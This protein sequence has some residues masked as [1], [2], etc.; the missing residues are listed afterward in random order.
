MIAKMASKRKAVTKRKQTKGRVIPQEQEEVIKEFWLS[1]DVSRPLPLKKRVKK[2]TVTYLL[3]TTYCT[4]MPTSFSKP[5]TQTLV[6][7]L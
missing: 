4:P 5:S 6:L 2:N 1:S 3:E 7:S